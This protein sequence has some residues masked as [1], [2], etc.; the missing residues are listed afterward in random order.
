MLV[1]D[2]ELQV[3]DLLE[4]AFVDEDLLCDRAHNG[5]EA[6]ELLRHTEYDVVVTDLSTPDLHATCSVIR[7]GMSLLRL[8]I[9]QRNI[10]GNS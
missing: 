10:M 2:N 9:F 5:I 4:R 3:R 6:F 1:V 7:L 8:R